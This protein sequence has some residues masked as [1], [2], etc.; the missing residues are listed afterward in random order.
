MPE[1]TIETTYRIP[2]YRQRRYD[3]PTLAEAC[4]L[5]IE[6]DDWE[7]AKEDHECAGETHVTGAW[8]G[9]V[10]PYSVP[11]LSVPSQFGET[12]RRKADHF[13]ELLNQLSFVAQS[14]G[15][16]KTDF[17]HRLPHAQAAVRKAHAILAG[18]RD[19]N[20]EVVDDLGEERSTA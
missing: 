3:A 5:A 17:E 11:P 12:V 13:A 9:D 15:I 2:I 7:G 6:D 14:M 1:F 4:R 18:A 19:P 10:P 8:A 20:E 16:S